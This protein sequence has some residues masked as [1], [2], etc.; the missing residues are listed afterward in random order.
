MSVDRRPLE[1]R[2]TPPGRFIQHDILDEH[3]L[4]QE[5]LAQ[6]LRVSR[7]T[8]NE[9][10]KGKRALTASMALRL[11]RLTGQ[12]PDYWL[13]LQRAVDLWDARQDP[14]NQIV[15]EIEPLQT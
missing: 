1:R 5:Q 10:V 11:G 3:G 8:V 9:L 4:T 12:S 7:L 13:A 2:P 14:D 6:R 15:E